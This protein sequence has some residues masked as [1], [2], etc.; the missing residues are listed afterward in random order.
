MVS[1]RN[2]GVRDGAGKKEGMGSIA[3]ST[4]YPADG[5]RYLPKPC[6]YTTGI[7][8]VGDKAATVAAGTFH[9][10]CVYGIHGVIIKFL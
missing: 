1:K 8:A 10:A 3:E 2:L 4:L 5:K 7:V 6:F 9:L